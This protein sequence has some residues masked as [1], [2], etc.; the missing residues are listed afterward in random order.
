MSDKPRK[1]SATPPMPRD[2]R[3][4]PYHYQK[5]SR[6]SNGVPSKPAAVQNGIGILCGNNLAV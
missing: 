3:M 1:D 2:I 5:D 6:G 4:P